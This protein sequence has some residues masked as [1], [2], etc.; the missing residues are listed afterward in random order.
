MYALGTAAAGIPVF[1]IPFGEE[2]PV[3]PVKGAPQQK[4]DAGP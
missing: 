1:T 3:L 4:D 2:G